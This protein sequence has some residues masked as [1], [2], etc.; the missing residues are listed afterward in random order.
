MS[1]SKPFSLSEDWVVVILGFIIIALALVG[2]AVPKPTFS[3]SNTAELTTQVISAE[4]LLTIGAQFL[5][6]YG[7]AILGAVLLGKS[8]KSLL[9][10]FPSV[11]II[12]VVALILAGN[13]VVQE[14][15]L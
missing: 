13:S 5:L 2:V 14:Y 3:W 4:N 11:F 8:L 15:N 12:T 7:A 1:T 10:V 9:I 6:V